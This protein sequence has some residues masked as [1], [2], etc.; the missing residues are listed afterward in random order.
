MT[1][2]LYWHAYMHRW[3]SDAGKKEVLMVSICIM[4]LICPIHSLPSS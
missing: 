4:L 3:L 1:P 2:G